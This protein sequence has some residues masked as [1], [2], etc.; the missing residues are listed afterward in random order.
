MLRTALQ[1]SATVARQSSSLAGSSVASLHH[2]RRCFSSR[3]E[4]IEACRMIETDAHG[5]VEKYVADDVLW[6]VTEPAGKSTPISGVFLQE[7]GSDDGML[8]IS[9]NTICRHLQ[10]EEG[11]CR[12]CIGATS[13]SFRGAIEA[14]VG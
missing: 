10:I 6:T 4:V 1:R 13:K 5:F 3:D 2:Q 14:L 11:I 9:F 8:T 7:R 12:G